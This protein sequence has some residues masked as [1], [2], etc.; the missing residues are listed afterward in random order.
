MLS[1]VNTF[2]RTIVLAAA[3]GLGGWLTWIV[4]SRLSGNERA[5]EERDQR[6]GELTTQVAEREV[7][8]GELDAE[9]DSLSAALRLLKVDHRLARIEVLEQTPVAG[10]AG[11][12]AVE[13]R[14]RFTEMGPDGRPLNEGRE[15]VVEGD[16][17]YVETLVVKFGDE[18][19][20][21]GDA[22]RGTSICLFKR[23]FGE[24]Q[25]P[26]EG[27]ELDSEGAQPAAY[28]DDRVDDALY[29]ELWQNF[30][31]Y[32]NDPEKAREKG[33]RALHGEAP[34]MKVRPGQSYKLELRSSGGLSIQAE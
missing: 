20:E 11:D 23:V 26:S 32:A 27:T 19:V 10:D 1:S 17:V 12:L 18:F 28:A 5:L 29:R 30:W 13:T 24:N 3:V 14:I 22:L 2:L 34:F 7:R 8:I 33:V 15:I 4:E 31:D 16:V 9:V 6:I 21:Q 25:R